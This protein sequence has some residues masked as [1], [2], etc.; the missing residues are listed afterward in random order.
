MTVVVIDTDIGGDI[1]DTWALAMLLGC[2][3]LDLRLVVTSGGDTTYRARVAAGILAAGG[4]DDVPLAIGPPT[5]L[6]DPEPGIEAL[7]GPQ[8]DFAGEVALDRYR[9]P[10]HDDGV[11]AL[12]DCVMD[13]GA[14]ARPTARSRGR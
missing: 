6:P 4:R 3:E 8:V 13:T 2:P 9:G 1:D 12:I 11:T 5:A 7:P 14:C 10:L